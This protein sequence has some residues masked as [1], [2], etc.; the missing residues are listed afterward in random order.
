[1]ATGL[2]SRRIELKYDYYSLVTRV[3]PAFIGNIR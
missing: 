3:N 2:R 1:M